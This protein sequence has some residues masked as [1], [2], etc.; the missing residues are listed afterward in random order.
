MVPKLRGRSSLG[1]MYRG[2]GG[3]YVICPVTSTTAQRKKFHNHCSPPPPP[4][5]PLHYMANSTFGKYYQYQDFK[6]A[7]GLRK[8]LAST[9]SKKK[10]SEVLISFGFLDISGLVYRCGK[11]VW[12]HPQKPGTKKVYSWCALV[13]GQTFCSFFFIH[14]QNYKYFF[15]ARFEMWITAQGRGIY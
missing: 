2:H 14:N 7:H 5:P 3:K 11:L 6:A 15:N 10:N 12:Q 9:T 8:E 1:L 4:P 13:L